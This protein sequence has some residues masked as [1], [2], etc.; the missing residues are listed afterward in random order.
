MSPQAKRAYWIVAGVMIAVVVTV[1]FV[2]GVAE[3]IEGE[4]L[5]QLARWS[6]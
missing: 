3:R 5:G 2:P 6:R 4:V 1:L